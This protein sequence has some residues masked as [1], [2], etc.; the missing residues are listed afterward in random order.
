MTCKFASN[1]FKLDH[2]SYTIFKV[3]VFL[4]RHSVVAM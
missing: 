4:C 2:D 1:D 3:C